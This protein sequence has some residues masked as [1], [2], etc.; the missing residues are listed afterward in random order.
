MLTTTA[1]PL[2]DVWEGILNY[3]ICIFIA[4]DGIR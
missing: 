3:E 1:S 4:L 2:T